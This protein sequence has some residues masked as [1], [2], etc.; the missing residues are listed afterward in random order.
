MSGSV[1][2]ETAFGPL[3]CHRDDEFITPTLRHQGRW[4][5][6]ETAYLSWRLQPGMT[7]VDVGANVGYFT[8]LASRRV[9]TGGRVFAFEPDPDSFALLEQ[10]IARNDCTN[11]TPFPYALGAHTGWVELHRARRNLGDHRT[12][13]CGEDRPTV[14]VRQLALDDVAGMPARLDVVKVDVQ[15][16][17]EAVLRGMERRLR[18]SPSVVVTVEFWP[19]A[20]TRF[21]SD[22]DALLAYYRSL[23]FGIEVQYFDRPFPVPLDRDE[24]MAACPVEQETGQATLVLTR[25]R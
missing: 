9:G 24:L 15:G 11:V 6:A 5:P 4:E 21:G 1:L 23:G 10:N 25:P 13:P 14:R 8:L 12:Y 2:V 19:H 3:A 22:P 16:S 20:L 18:D 17:E 7:F